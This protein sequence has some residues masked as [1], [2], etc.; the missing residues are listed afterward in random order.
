MLAKG[1][2]SPKSTKINWYVNASFFFEFM[3]CG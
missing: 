1:L 2:N 3:S